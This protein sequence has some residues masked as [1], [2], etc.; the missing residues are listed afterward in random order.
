MERSDVEVER[1]DRDRIRQFS[2]ALIGGIVGELLGLRLTNDWV[3]AALFAINTAAFGFVLEW[4][5]IASHQDRHRLR[6]VE[7]KV[8]KMV[9]HTAIYTEEGKFEGILSK[10]RRPEF[11]GLTWVVADFVS[12]KLSKHFPNDDEIMITEVGPVIYSEWVAQWL[13]DCENSVWFIIPYTPKEWFRALLKGQE[14]VFHDIGQEGQVDDRIV[15]KHV[16][17]LSNCRVN[18]KKRIVI[19]T[20]QQW[21]E[22][23]QKDN[24][25][26]LK[27]F[28]RINKRSAEL[29]FIISD[30]ARRDINVDI[31]V[32]SKDYI[33]LDERVALNWDPEEQCLKFIL[34]KETVVG[35]VD[36]CRL[37]IR[38]DQNFCYNVKRLEERL[39]CQR[40]A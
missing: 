3:S 9:E 23:W 6:A 10:L 39:R 5:L 16:S 14:A 34:H 20:Q 15:P 19:V 30:E 11:G 8:R 31:G 21:D 4:A 22:M 28:I 36:E 38:P 35:L 2:F 13:D 7:D 29:Y 24:M 32:V 27:E 17:A 25:P 40:S 26:Y 37:L 12:K 18:D 33:I 1:V